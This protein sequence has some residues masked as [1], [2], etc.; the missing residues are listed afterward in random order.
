[1]R[2]L[3]RERGFFGIGWGGWPQINQRKQVDG[4][5]VILA[6]ENGAAGGFD[7][8]DPRGAVE[9]AGFGVGDAASEGMARMVSSVPGAL[10][11]K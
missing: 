4:A 10:S 6:D 1:M 9:D 3:R 2:D 7:E 8:A 5:I 11:S